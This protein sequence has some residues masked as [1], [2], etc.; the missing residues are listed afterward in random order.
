MLI[1]L[2]KVLFLLMSELRIKLGR[3]VL[4]LK[5]DR[6]QYVKFHWKG[7]EMYCFSRS[8]TQNFL[9]PKFLKTLSHLAK[10]SSYALDIRY[11]LSFLYFAI[12]LTS[13][14]TR[15]VTGEYEKRGKYLSWYSWD[16]T[17]INIIY[18]SY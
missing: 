16:N 14:E 2:Y 12:H 11:N 17:K 1:T 5:K 8:S 7:S 13:I 18:F 3:T 6:L 15:K 9:Q 4:R 10:I